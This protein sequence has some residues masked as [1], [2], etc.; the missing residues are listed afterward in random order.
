M[1]I[2]PIVYGR[3]GVQRNRTSSVPNTTKNLLCVQHHLEQ[4]HFLSIILPPDNA[5]IYVSLPL[6]EKLNQIGDQQVEYTM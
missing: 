2:I 4:S 3:I 6:L 1:S 5:D